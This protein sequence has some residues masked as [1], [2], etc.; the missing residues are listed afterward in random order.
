MPRAA[1]LG[2]LVECGAGVVASVTIAP[3]AKACAD[4]PTTQAMA[5]YIVEYGLAFVCSAIDGVPTVDGSPR[6][7][8]QLQATG[9]RRYRP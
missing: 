1:V 4:D 2:A 8:H 3:S 7:L 5:E 6:W 9:G